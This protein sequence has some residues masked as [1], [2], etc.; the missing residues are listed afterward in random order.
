MC[1]A[2]VNR[3]YAE[4]FCT[5]FPCMSNTSQYL[6]IFQLT[7]PSYNYHDAQSVGLCRIVYFTH[8]LT[9][10]TARVVS[11]GS[12]LRNLT[13]CTPT[14]PMS[15]RY[16]TRKLL[17]RVTLRE[18]PVSGVDPAHRATNWVHR[19]HH[20]PRFSAQHILVQNSQNQQLRWHNYQYSFPPFIE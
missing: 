7:V 2:Y 8:P 6:K 12:R 16:R 10:P 13:P 1:S 19:T 15:S 3:L 9:Q 5:C 4:K 18:S 14:P 17:R 11:W 20:H